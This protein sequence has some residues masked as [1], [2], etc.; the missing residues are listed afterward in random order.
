MPPRT[1]ASLRLFAFLAPHVCACYTMSGTD[2]AHAAI[3]LQ[4]SRQNSCHRC[5]VWLCQRCVMPATDMLHGATSCAR[6]SHDLAHGAVCQRFCHAMSGTV[7]TCD[8]ACFASATVC[9]VLTPQALDRMSATD[10][11]YGATS[12]RCYAFSPTARLLPPYASPIQSCPSP[13]IA[14]DIVPRPTAHAICTGIV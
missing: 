4:R 12:E 2:R 7:R 3:R 14:I 10:I 6:F 9:S 8:A 13:S 5:R 11:A 1:V